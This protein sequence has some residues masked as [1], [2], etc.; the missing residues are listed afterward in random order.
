MIPPGDI[1]GLLAALRDGDRTALDRLFPLVYQE[2]HARAHHQLARRRPGDT[3]ST[4]ALGARGL[5]QA[6]RQ[7]PPDV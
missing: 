5:P 6:Y 1:T 7:R 2:L 3:L 4:T